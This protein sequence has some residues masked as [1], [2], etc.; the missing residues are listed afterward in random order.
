MKREHINDT[1]VGIAV[2]AALVLLLASLAVVTGRGGVSTSYF[3]TYRNV[4]GL[5]AGAPVFYE[6]FRIGQVGKIDP[7]RGAERTRYKVE[8]AVRRDW[9]IPSDSVARLSS[10]GLLADVSIAIREGAAK[11]SLKAGAELKGEEGADVFAALNELAGEVTILTRERISPLV[12]TLSHRVDSITT[13]LDSS[14]PLILG[15][16]ETLLKK[17]NEAALS[18][19]D[20]LSTGNREQLSATLS[21]VRQVTGELQ[22]TQRRLDSL[23]VDLKSTVAEDRP[24]LRSAVADLAQITAALS[25]RIDSIAHNLESSSRNFNEFTREVRKHPNRLLVTPKA[26]KVKE[27]DQ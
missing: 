9:P 1:L 20:V 3:V 16:A 25:H 18:V 22:G 23:L 14:T 4:T 13:N 7:L 26:D 21:N 27:E 15:Q 5:K 8:L 2:L 19:N 11:D 24:A 10:S 17:L 6:G 12:E